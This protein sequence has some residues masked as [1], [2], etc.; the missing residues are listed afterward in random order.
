M[1]LTGLTKH[2]SLTFLSLPF[3]TNFFINELSF[4]SERPFIVVAAFLV[5]F[6]VID[7][8]LISKI[9]N[10]LLELAIFLF[11]SVFL[12]SF[13]LYYDTLHV[14]HALRFRYFLAI[15]SVF[16]LLIFA[17]VVYNNLY[18]FINIFLLFF[19]LSFVFAITSEQHNRSV[20]LNN[21]N[22]KPIQKNW[23]GV[24]K[25]SAPLILV[26]LD[27]L[28]SGSESF[29]FSKDSLDLKVSEKFIPLGFEVIDDFPSVALSTKF[30][31]PSIFNFNLHSSNNELASIDSVENEVRTKSTYDFLY[32]NNLL[33]DSLA[34]KGVSAVNYGL[35]QMKKANNPGEIYPWFPRKTT[36]RILKIVAGPSFLNRLLNYTIVKNIYLKY[37]FS[38]IDVWLD[39]NEDVWSS[40]SSENF[41]K[42][43]FY[44]YHLIA[45]HFPYYD[46]QTI[47]EEQKRLKDIG[48]AYNPK[49]TSSYIG[50]RRLVLNKLFTLLK[51]QNLEGVRVI[52][53]SDHGFRHEPGMKPNS[54]M[55]FLKGFNKGV[56]VESVQNIAYLIN[57]SF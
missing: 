50:H 15:L 1:G 44:H 40:L 30:S 46:R 39:H 24:N 41:E 35:T 49:D 32:R 18:P 34:S 29:L 23:G 28:A 6:I 38:P 17:L 20:L 9:K 55:L 11:L 51:E 33:L 52:I 13:I 45:P 56:K 3:I 16:F 42:N 43:H 14:I 12:Y 37:N 47:N 36:N 7:V 31:L 4:F 25:S 8:F 2:K 48:G 53:T 10:K 54:T 57:L 19:S 26:I 21:L 27:E 5:V 22:F